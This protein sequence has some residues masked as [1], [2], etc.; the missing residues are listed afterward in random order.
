MMEPYRMNSKKGTGFSFHDFDVETMLNTIDRA[1]ALYY[2]KP[3]S[4][5]ALQ[6]RAMRNTDNSWE[7]SANEYIEHYKYLVY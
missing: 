6:I 7:K 2:D 4:F 5:E 1:L 3:D